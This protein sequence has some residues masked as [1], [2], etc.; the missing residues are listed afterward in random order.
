[1]GQAIT[2]D[3][4]LL[5]EL[6][7]GNVTYRT[8]SECCGE[9]KIYAYNNGKNV[10]LPQEYNVVLK[11]YDDWLKLFYG[12][13]TPDKFLMGIEECCE[14]DGIGFVNPVIKEKHEN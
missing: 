8:C 5:R 4:E 3:K 11:E 6:I 12:T 7:L 10:C 14:C 13:P 9:G 1:M 2:I